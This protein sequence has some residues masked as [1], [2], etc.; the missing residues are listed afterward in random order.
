MVLP[1]FPDNLI[2]P[3]R[4]SPGYVAAQTSIRTSYLPGGWA[5]MYG[6]QFALDY[7]G[8]GGGVYNEG[9]KVVLAD[10]GGSGYIAVRNVPPATL[11]QAWNL[12]RTGQAS[13]M[14][15][16]NA[17]ATGGGASFDGAGKGL[18]LLAAVGVVVLVL[19]VR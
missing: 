4:G 19:A 1:A 9:L 6:N 7:G 2:V 12:V 17:P 8:P 14:P 5:S 11:V 13:A 18:L 3:A 10:Q 16:G 15:M